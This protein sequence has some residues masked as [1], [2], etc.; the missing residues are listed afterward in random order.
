MNGYSMSVQLNSLYVFE[1][2]QEPKDWYANEILRLDA[3][4]F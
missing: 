3:I 4:V 1:V 2:E